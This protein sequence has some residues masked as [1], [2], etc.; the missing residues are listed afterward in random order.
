MGMEQRPEQRPLVVRERGGLTFD[1]SPVFDPQPSRQ[2]PNLRLG[3]RQA[4]GLTVV[5][6]L[7]FVFD[8][9][10][11][12]VRVAQAVTILRRQ[13]MAL[14]E[15][16]ERRQGFQLPH[17]GIFAGVNELEHLADKLNLPDA[18]TTELD[19]GAGRFGLV[20]AA[21]DPGFHILE[22]FDRREIE[23]APKHKRLHLGNETLPQGQVSGN[24]PSLEQGR[25]LP[26]LAPG[27]VIAQGIGQGIHHRAVRAVRPQAQVNPKHPPTGHLIA[28]RPGQFLGQVGKEL[29]WCQAALAAPGGVPGIALVHIDQID[30]GA[31]IQILAAEL[32]HAKDDEAER[33][34]VGRDGLA[35]Q[36]TQP[37]S[38]VLVGDLDRRVSQTAQLPGR[39][40][41]P[42]QRQQVTGTDAQVRA[43]TVDP[44][45]VPELLLGQ[46]VRQP[47]AQRGQMLGKAGPRGLAIGQKGRLPSLGLTQQDCGEML[48][49][50]EHKKQV[51]TP[52]GVSQ[53]PA[54]AGAVVE[55]A[56]Q[57]RRRQA[58]VRRGRH[59]GRNGVPPGGQ[60]FAQGQEN[61][62]GLGD[63]RSGG[64]HGGRA[65]RVA[66][67]KPATRDPYLLSV[68]HAP[69]SHLTLDS[70][71]STSEPSSSLLC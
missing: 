57:I 20:Q 46:L 23:I 42:G 22:V 69:I 2:H 19:V 4:V 1:F 10:Q 47:G 35:V 40:F 15:A 39:L 66:S 28:Q 44:Q 71:S 52:P 14:D 55:Q 43:V 37:R 60:A 3:V 56:A 49:C 24:R 30:V 68:S 29:A 70:S 62:E 50:A 51:G 64:G 32:A 31:E 21:L 63:G 38:A 6:D 45:P 18:A 5:N 33:P 61:V 11:K 25:P 59:A 16:V 27:F 13:I 36:L 67:R 34:A 26:G 9:A 48:A 54:P 65:G 8:L 17:M 58:R 53:H 7:D 12:A 41:Q